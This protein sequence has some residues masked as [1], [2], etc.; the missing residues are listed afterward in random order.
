MRF[1]NPVS[2]TMPPLVADERTALCGQLDFHR[3]T[4]LAKLDGLTDEQAAR[5]MVPS[6][7]S[8]LALL[9]HLVF[10]EHFWYVRVFAG[11]DEPGPYVDAEG[12]AGWGVESTDTLA[13]VAAEYLRACQRSRD[14]VAE[15]VSFDEV[16]ITPWG[17]PIDLRG[18]TV[19]MIEETARHN[20]HA[21]ILR[22]L[23]DGTTGF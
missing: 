21:D 12:S 10:G 4:I 16:A 7:V 1:H 8:L 6:G 20:G 18:I 5:V 3:A 13:A 23:I 2:R 14:I 17:E 11:L 19:H 22:E 15:S 9:K